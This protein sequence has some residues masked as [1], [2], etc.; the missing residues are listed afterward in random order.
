MAVA[1]ASRM[2]FA[3]LLLPDAV[4]IAIACLSGTM[5]QA[6]HHCYIAEM[7]LVAL[8]L[9]C[10]DCKGNLI[11]LNGA[12]CLVQIARDFRRKKMMADVMSGGKGRQQLLN[13]HADR[14]QARQSSFCLYHL[15]WFKL[16]C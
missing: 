12:F 15:T 7:M 10:P 3:V 9:L 13:K 11:L 14:S 4:D 8:H 16:V 5:Q 2:S 6:L 1:T